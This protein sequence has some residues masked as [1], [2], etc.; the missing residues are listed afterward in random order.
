MSQLIYP[1]KDLQFLTSFLLI[2]LQP[3]VGHIILLLD[4]V[5]KTEDFLRVWKEVNKNKSL[6]AEIN[7]EYTQMK[8]GEFFWRGNFP[9]F[10]S[11]WDLHKQL[12]TLALAQFSLLTGHANSMSSSDNEEHELET[13]RADKILW[14]LLS[15]IKL[16][17]TNRRSCKK[18]RMAGKNCEL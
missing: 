15:T 16:Y 11:R 17:L 8:K 13:N 1:E 14:K 2:T 6:T 18:R 10:F 12:P 5:N 4:S 9:H 7:W 3:H